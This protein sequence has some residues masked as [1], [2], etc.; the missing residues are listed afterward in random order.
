[1][2]SLDQV[3]E[4][5]E[6]I[7]RRFFDDLGRALRNVDFTNHGNPKEHPIVPHVHTWDWVK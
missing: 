2:S 4:S 3:N 7:M 1:M 6:T 5:G